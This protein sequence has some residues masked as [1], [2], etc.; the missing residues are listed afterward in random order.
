MAGAVLRSYLDEARLG[1]LQRYDVTAERWE[2]RAV[3]CRVKHVRSTSE[4]KAG[5]KAPLKGMR[6][7][8]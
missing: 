2:A 5:P 8:N 7:V 6:E 3:A 4:A 1:R